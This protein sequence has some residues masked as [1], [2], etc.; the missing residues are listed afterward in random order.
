MEEKEATAEFTPLYCGFTEDTVKLF[1][2]GVNLSKECRKALQEVE[3]SVKQVM[4]EDGSSN[5]VTSDLKTDE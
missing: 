3:K 1:Q 5:V 2:E 4:D